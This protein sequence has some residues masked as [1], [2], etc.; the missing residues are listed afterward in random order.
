[1]ELEDNGLLLLPKRKDADAL[2]P[3]V[4]T[5][6]QLFGS[7]ARTQDGEIELQESGTARSVQSEPNAQSPKIISSKAVSQHDNY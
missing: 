1:M 5:S 2:A 6:N 3:A 7:I 4:I